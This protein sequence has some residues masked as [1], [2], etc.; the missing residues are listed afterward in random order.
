MAVLLLESH[1]DDLA[2]FC[3]YTAL[4]LKPTAITVLGDARVQERYGISKEDRQAENA[5]AL[6]ILGVTNWMVWNHSDVE[7]NWDA[8]RDD[9]R[10]YFAAHEPEEVWAPLVE[11][12][13]GHD[14]HDQVGLLASEVFGDRCRFYATYRRG[15]GRTRTDNE[16]IPEPDWPATKFKAMSAYASQIN[17]ENCRPWFAAADSLREWRA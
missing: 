16:V 12:G 10:R 7:P 13:N 15:S 1:H 3:A 11:Q 8:V 14:Q 6:N 4:R 9:M 2:L 5:E 17:L